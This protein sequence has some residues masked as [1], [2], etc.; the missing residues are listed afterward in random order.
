MT[1]PQIDQVRA[2]LKAGKSITPA[3]A[4]AVYGISRL[5]VHVD[6]LRR[7]GLDIDTILKRD[8]MGKQYGEYRLRKAIALGALVQVRPGNGIGLPNWVRRLKAAS[9][10]GLAPNGAVL[11]RFIR[12]QNMQSLWLMEKELVRVD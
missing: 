4:M 10:T 2:H 12:G 8:E 11:V 1:T 3:I 6:Y 9:V 7:Q 5:A